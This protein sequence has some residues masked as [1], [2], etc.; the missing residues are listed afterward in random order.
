M[1]DAENENEPAEP[2]PGADDVKTIKSHNLMD[3]DVDLLQALIFEF[4]PF[5]DPKTVEAEALGYP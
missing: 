3:V 4:D 1:A 2:E 5:S